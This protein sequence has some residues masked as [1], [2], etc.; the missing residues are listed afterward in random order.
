MKKV[1]LGKTG[2]FVSQVRVGCM[3]MG[4]VAVCNLKALGISLCEEQMDIL[5][6][7]SV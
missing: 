1:E 3:L 4:S 6:K 2:V 7:A 5:Y